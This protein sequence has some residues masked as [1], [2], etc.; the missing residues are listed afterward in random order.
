MRRLPWTTRQSL[1]GPDLTL[2]SYDEEQRLGLTTNYLFDAVPAAGERLDRKRRWL[3]DG[4][5]ALR[6]IG[7]AL[8]SCLAGPTTRASESDKR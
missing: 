1:D 8:G 7:G 2:A 4:A 5:S 6:Q 3:G